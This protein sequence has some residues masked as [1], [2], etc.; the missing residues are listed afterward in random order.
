[1]PFALNRRIQPPLERFP[2]GVVHGFRVCGGWFSECFEKLLERM[3]TGHRGGEMDFR[4]HGNHS[5][6]PQAIYRAAGTMRR[7]LHFN[8]NAGVT[9]NRQ[10]GSPDMRKFIIPIAPLCLPVQRKAFRWLLDTETT[11]VAP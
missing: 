7:H 3:N 4:K 2:G 8:C 11:D 10:S 5:V 6:M 1:M 9:G